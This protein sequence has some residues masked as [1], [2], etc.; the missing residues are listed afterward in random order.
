[1]LHFTL[2]LL[3]ALVIPWLSVVAA[4]T[5]ICLTLKRARNYPESTL[6]MDQSL[7]SLSRR[8]AS[9]WFPVKP[10]IQFGSTAGIEFFGVTGSIDFRAA[11]KH[12]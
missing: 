10:I 9:D 8:M 3:H 7:P 5:Y 6:S 4:M 1:M 11:L 2:W 12:A